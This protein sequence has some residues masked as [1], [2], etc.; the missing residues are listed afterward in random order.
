MHVILHLKSWTKNI[1]Y[2]TF[3]NVLLWKVKT[4]NKESANIAFLQN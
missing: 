2:I 1:Y 3:K 4:N